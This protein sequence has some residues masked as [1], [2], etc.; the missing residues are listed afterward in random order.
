M[1]VLFVCPTSTFGG[2]E[3]YLASIVNAALRLPRVTCVELVC[4][5]NHMLTYIDEKVTVHEGIDCLSILDCVKLA[6]RV[7][8]MGP[9]DYVFING[10]DTV[11]KC[12]PLIRGQVICCGHHNFNKFNRPLARGTPIEALHSML[13][14]M[15]QRAIVRYAFTGF[16]WF[17][18]INRVSRDNVRAVV[19]GDNL[20]YIPY[21]VRPIEVVRRPSAKVRIGRIGRLEKVK[22]N[23]FLIRSFLRLL[24]SGVNAEL[25]FAGS[26]PEL[27][28]LQAL[29]RELGI[30]DSVLFLG[31]VEP[32]EFYSQVDMTVSSSFY[33]A[34]PLVILESFSCGIPVVATRVGGVPEVVEDGVNGLLVEFGDEPGMCEALRRLSTDQELWERISQNQKCSFLARHSAEIMIDKTLGLFE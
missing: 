28:N 8:R 27:A 12:A 23:D 3:V 26:G 20:V 19:E 1:K 14:R 17:I 13:R 18:C 10:F 33:D 11:A 6:L 16:R 32:A 30:D 5:P 24:K 4:P 7:N 9:Y 21:G 2:A 31:L 34:S 15:L 25:I 22:G 29:S